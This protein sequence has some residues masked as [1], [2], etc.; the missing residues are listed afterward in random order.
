M[1]FVLG[2]IGLLI[3]FISPGFIGPGVVGVIAL[4]LAFLGFGNLPVSWIA[5]GLLLFSVV[6]FYLETVQPGI[7]VFGIGGA[8]CLILGAVLLFGGRFST[9][10]IPEPNFVVNP[11]LIGALGGG[12]VATW[13]VFMRLVKTEGGTSS[14][15]ISASEADLEEEW[16]VATSDLAP[17]GKVWVANEEWTATTDATDVIKEGAPRSA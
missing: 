13:L 16:G 3:E 17:S 4:A 11:W 8:V 5:V 12:V 15:Y 6:L 7:G 1:L 10:D 9:P 2:G 14:G